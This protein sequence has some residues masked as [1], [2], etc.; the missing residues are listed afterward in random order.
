M[1]VNSNIIPFFSSFSSCD[2]D[3]LKKQFENY[4]KY[5]NSYI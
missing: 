5:P 1:N 3:F 4:Q 2:I